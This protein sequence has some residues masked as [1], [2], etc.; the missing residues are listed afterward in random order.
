MRRTDAADDPG[1]FLSSD[2]F[3]EPIC[4]PVI[5]GEGNVSG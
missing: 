1:H 2:M 5:T 3:F 4:E